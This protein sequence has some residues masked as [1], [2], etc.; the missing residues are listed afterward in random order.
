MWPEFYPLIVCIIIVMRCYLTSSKTFRAEWAFRWSLSFALWCP[1][2]DNKTCRDC[3][4]INLLYS[5]K[6]WCFIHFIKYQI[7]KIQSRSLGSKTISVW[8]SYSTLLL[9]LLFFHCQLRFSGCMLWWYSRWLYG[10]T[11]STSVMNL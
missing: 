5:C 11:R 6:I 10:N 2:I 1:H 3:K 9:A 8:M 4:F 7:Q